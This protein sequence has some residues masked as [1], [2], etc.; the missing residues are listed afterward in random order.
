MIL[1]L[2][3]SG[4]NLGLALCHDGEV[5]ASRLSHP[6]LKHGEILQAAIGDFLGEAQIGF[7]KLTAIAVT[8]GPGSYTGLRIGLAAA[9]GYAYALRLP[10]VGFSTLQ[11]GTGFLRG[12]SPKVL[13]IIDAR[14]QELY[15]AAFDCR[16]DS[17]RNLVPDS[18]GRLED[19]RKLIDDDT[20]IVGPAAIKE[21]IV[22]EKAF[23]DYHYSDNLNLA[24]PA[25]LWAARKLQ[26]GEILDTALA[27]PVYLRV[28][29]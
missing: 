22:A 4:K 24:E 10:I 5:I 9:K 11:A 2:D 3:T 19:V 20:I 18:I 7:E 16:G 14:R 25:G 6:G 8:L 17:P 21:L 1:A 28:E 23:S 12:I 13:S 15:Y 29:F 27:V 26:A